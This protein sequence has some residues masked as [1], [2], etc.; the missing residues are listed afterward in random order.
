MNIIEQGKQ[1]VQSLHELAGRTVWERR[2]C[3]HCGS[4][5]TCKNGSCVRHPWF[6]DGRR[7]VRVQRHWCHE[8]QCSYA[9]QSALFVRSSWYAR[10]VH[11]CAIAL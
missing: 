4:M 10:E 9:E 7:T 1:F 5:L 2:R 8:S 3:P 11:R 6:L